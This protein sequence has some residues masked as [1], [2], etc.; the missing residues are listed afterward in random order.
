MVEILAIV[1]RNRAAATKQELARIE[2]PGYFQFPVL[3]R[4]RQRGLRDQDG[5]A[6]LRFL[7]KVLFRVVVDDQQ[8]SEVIEAI[9]RA[10]QTGQFGDGRIFVIEATRADRIS[11][12][13]QEPKQA[14][15]VS[16]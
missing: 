5:E 4:G 3:G 7:P 6:G 11:T 2:C 14:V 9:V 10:N 13:G 8:A 12:S 1:R 16:A 15:E